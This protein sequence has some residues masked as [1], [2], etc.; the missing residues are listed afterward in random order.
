MPFGLW[1]QMGPIKHVLH[2]V[3][4]AP[5]GEY[6][7]TVP[8]RWRCGLF[9]KLL[10]PL[11]CMP[12]VLVRVLISY[13]WRE[14]DLSPAPLTG[15]TML[16]YV[17]IR[18]AI[19]CHKPTSALPGQFSAPID[20]SISVDCLSTQLITPSAVAF[21]RRLRRHETN[22]SAY[23]R[24]GLRRPSTVCHRLQS[25]ER[26]R[27][28]SLSRWPPARV[29]ASARRRRRFSLLI[30]LSRTSTALTLPERYDSDGVG[31]TRLSQRHDNMT[32]SRN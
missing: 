10:R 27:R 26:S 7:R 14:L 8:V 31:R 18:R 16:S 15:L 28:H 2:G 23:S 5:P 11:V 25:A 20:Q 29:P 13:G 19:T 17:P 1:T 4:L 22:D 12:L 30:D 32:R 3:T 9:V 24:A 6:D 21:P